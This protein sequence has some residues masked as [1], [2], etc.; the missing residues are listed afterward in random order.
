MKRLKKML[1]THT[2]RRDETKKQNKSVKKEGDGEENY[3]LHMDT[4]VEVRRLN[5]TI[6]NIS[7]SAG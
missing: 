7:V 5:K 3:F 2:K 1:R 4:Q 6:K